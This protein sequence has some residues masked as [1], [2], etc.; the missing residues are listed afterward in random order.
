MKRRVLIIQ[1]TVKQYR[2]PF[3][4]QLALRL[5]QEG[6]TLRV[7]YGNPSEYEA[8]KGD[9]VNLP[10]PLGIKVKNRR[11]LRGKILWQP[12]RSEAAKADL[13]IVE[14]AAR[15]LANYPLLL[16]SRLGLRRTAFWGRGRDRQ[17]E[18]EGI[19]ERLR[20]LMLPHAHWWFA[21]TP[22][23]AAC[24]EEGGMDPQR[25]T[26]VYN[27]LDTEGFL[28]LLKGV[29]QGMLPIARKRL[30]IPD[31]GIVAL[32]CGSFCRGK[33]LDFLLESAR[34]VRSRLPSFQLLLVGDGPDAWAVHRHC[35][36]ESWL[37]FLGPRFGTEKALCFRM[38]RLFIHPGAL[39]LAVLDAF[40]AG[41]P[42]VTADIPTH[43]PEIEYIEKDVN[44]IITPDDPSS[45]ADGCLRVLNDDQLAHRL[46]QGARESAARYSLEAMVERFTEGIFRALGTSVTLRECPAASDETACGM[47]IRP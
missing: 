29:P 37:H 44:G 45:F 38:A 25:I 20:R 42:M 43:G 40:A 2:V 4:E 24:V 13:V 9:S 26:T 30:G 12:L 47:E 7:A 28:R 34:L 15:H 23:S 32:Y 5:E 14:H 21:Y 46:S 35:E 3:F 41:L 19:A 10:P 36:G 27:S 18:G 31:D 1:E 11:L 6:V 17:S 22:G 16:L 39:G 8:L 33:R